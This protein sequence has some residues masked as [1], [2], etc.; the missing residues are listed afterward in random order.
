M[1]ILDGVYREWLAQGTIY[2]DVIESAGACR[3]APGPLPG[4]LPSAC[5]A[6]SSGVGTKCNGQDVM[7]LHPGRCIKVFFRHLKEEMLMAVLLVGY[8]G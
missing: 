1:I 4:R 3:C 6:S 5:K 2:P 7:D 8:I